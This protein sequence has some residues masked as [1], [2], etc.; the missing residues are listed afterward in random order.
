MS[1]IF[2]NIFSREIFGGI[3][4]IAFGTVFAAFRD[5]RVILYRT[6]ARRRR[7]FRRVFR[8]LR[9]FY[10]CALTENTPLFKGCE[11]H[12]KAYGNGYYFGHGERQPR[13]IETYSG[14]RPEYGNET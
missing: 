3:F 10:P 6:T 1:T 14:E 8:I 5:R 2:S 9:A 4:R 11:V 13:I 12:G 7:S